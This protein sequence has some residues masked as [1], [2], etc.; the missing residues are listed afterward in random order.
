MAFDPST[1]IWRTTRAVARDAARAWLVR[2]CSMTPPEV[3]AG[4]GG[5]PADVLGE[6]THL[7]AVEGQDAGEVRAAA[8][9]DG[10]TRGD[11]EVVDPPA[12]EET[13][14]AVGGHRRAGAQDGLG[15]LQA[16]RGV[17]ELLPRGKVAAA[18]GVTGHAGDERAVLEQEDAGTLHLAEFGELAAGVPEQVVH[19]LGLARGLDEPEQYLGL[20]GA[21]PLRPPGPGLRQCDGHPRGGLAQQMGS[22]GR[23]RLDR[24]D[25]DDLAVHEQG[26]AVRRPQATVGEVL[27]R[28]ASSVGMGHERLAAADHGGHERGAGQGDGGALRAVRRRPRRPG[29]RLPERHDHPGRRLV[30]PHGH[31][32]GAGLGAQALQ[33]AVHRGLGVVGR[34]RPRRA[35]HRRPRAGQRCPAVRPSV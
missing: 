10:E 15:Q 30:H 20:L 5:Q 3:G 31:P 17:A 27:V 19:R 12:G 24:E 16:F 14:V 35:G 23:G 7:R 13:R 34:R 8:D 9:R 11:V 6:G 29:D 22:G 18:V 26:L 2:A 28:G 32:G 4:G 25:A 21:A 33:L 1:S